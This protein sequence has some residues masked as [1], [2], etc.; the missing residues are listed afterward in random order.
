MQDN[1]GNQVGE[2]VVVQRLP[3]LWHLQSNGF[4]C[5]LVS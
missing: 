5:Q 1:E 4:V 2:I 3:V